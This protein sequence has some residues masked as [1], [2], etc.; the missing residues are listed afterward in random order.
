MRDRL[1]L[2]ALLPSRELSLAEANKSLE[3]IVPDLAS[4][5]PLISCLADPVMPPPPRGSPLRTR[6][7][8]DA[9]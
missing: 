7:E 3:T 9:A 8:R 2:A 5:Q 1:I 4:G 6:L